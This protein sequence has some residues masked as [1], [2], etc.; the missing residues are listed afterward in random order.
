MLASRLPDIA[1]MYRNSR[2]KRARSL[3]SPCADGGSRANDC[4]PFHDTRQ[5]PRCPVNVQE[6]RKRQPR[7]FAFVHASVSADG[8]RLRVLLCVDP[9]IPRGPVGRPCRGVFCWGALC[10]H[11]VKPYPPRT[12]PQR[13]FA[14][15]DNRHTTRYTRPPCP[16]PAHAQRPHLLTGNAPLYARKARRSG[17]KRT[18]PLS[19]FGSQGIAIARCKAGRSKQ[20]GGLWRAKPPAYAAGA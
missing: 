2:F 13:V 6:E 19:F 12:Q 20:Q 17:S 16:T 1:V 14:P 10:F 3:R 18:S 4:L 7:Q 11:A 5:P 8:D 9:R 15:I